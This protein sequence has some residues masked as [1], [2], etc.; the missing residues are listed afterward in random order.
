MR[1]SALFSRNDARGDQTSETCPRCSVEGHVAAFRC[2]DCLCSKLLCDECCLEVHGQL[3]FHSIQKWDGVCFLKQS[4]KALGLRIQVGHAQADERCPHSVP[5]RDGFVVLHDNGIHQVALDYCGCPGSEEHHLQLLR[6]RLFPAT[7]RRPQTCATFACLDRC[8]VFS[9]KPKMNAFDFYDSLERLTDGAGEKPPDRYR[10]LLRMVREWRHLLL[11]K[12]GGRFGYP[13]DE[14]ENTTPGE[15][16]VLCPACPR[17]GVNLPENWQDIDPKLAFIYTLFLAMD[18]CFQLKRRLVASEARDPSLG[19]GFACMVDAPPYREFLR[20]STNK[21]EMSTCSGLKALDHSNTKFSKGYAATG[22]GMVVC[23][24]HEFVQPTS[25]GD[26]Q[27]GERYSNMDFL[28]ASMLRHLSALLRKVVSYDIVCQWYKNLFKRLTE[29]PT[30]LK[31][32]L[33]RR[34][35]QFVVPKL[36]ILGHIAQCRSTFNLDFTSGS[37]QTDAEGIERAWAAAGG[38]AGSTKMMGPGARSDMLDAYWTFWNWSKVLGLPHLLRQRLEVAK[39]ELEKQKEAFEL[40]SEE[41]SEHIPEWQKMVDDYEADKINNKNPYVAVAKGKSEAE[42]RLMLRQEEDKQEREGRAPLRVHDVSPVGFLEFALAVEMEQRRV[43]AQATLKK[44]H[45]TAE[46]IQLGSARR[47]LNHDQ[48][49]LRKL[50]ATFTPEAL[51]KLAALSLPE[52]VLAEDIPLFLPSAL[53][54][55]WTASA[56]PALGMDAG[57]SQLLSMERMLRCAQMR[58]ALT[59]VRNHLHIKWRLLKFKEDHVRNQAMNT[60]SRTTIAR[61]ESQVSLFADVYQIA[62]HAVLQIEGGDEAKVGFNRL[63]REDIRYMEDPEVFSKKAELARV[64]DEKWEARLAQIRAEEGWSEEVEEREANSHLADPEEDD[65][66]FMRGSNKTV[67]SWI[68]RGTDAKGS[69]VEMQEA[70]RIEWCKARARRLRWEEEV[71]IVGD[72]T[73]RVA[74]T[75]EHQAGVWEEKARRVPVGAIPVQEAEGMIAYALKQA[76]MHRQ[77]AA[78]A[79]IIAVEPRVARGR[80]RVRVVPAPVDLLAP[81]VEQ[82]DEEEDSGDETDLHEVEERGDLDSDDNF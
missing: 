3:P 54:A 69:Q 41:Q 21:Q 29:L 77:L 5:A 58:S 66:F 38:L 23:A 39:V 62:W 20:N 9:L 70:V 53:A 37:G 81:A 17:P 22:V 35:T 78:R 75:H 67:M 11:L 7:T 18:A 31:F 34:F 74:A 15:L 49:N 4:L 45:S 68:W 27:K 24:R 13:S 64:R 33:M 32:V 1:S 14:A 10:A 71:C 63:R 51:I 25:V 65:E 43:K 40:F 36:H 42:V 30:F 26:L 59:Y 61:N 19:P 73:R 79:N 46:E 56:D 47:K 16:A 52:T 28:F 60:R 72:E 55:T 6:S 80:R 57:R 8:T 12:R 76:S 82:G 44:S 2:E 50:Q 48:Q